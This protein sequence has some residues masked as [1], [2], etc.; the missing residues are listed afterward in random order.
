MTHD[1]T[2]KLIALLVVA[3]PNHEK[4]RDEKH[5]QMTV[6]LWEQMFAGD[7]FRLVQLATEK[8]IATSKW[9]PSIAELRDIIA[10]IT[11]PGV[12]P[13]DEAWR[14]VTKLLAIHE[15]LYQPT[16][17]YLPP[18][19]AEAV[20]TVGYD[21]LQAIHRAAA[22]GA[23]S[24]AGLD[25]VAFL[26]AYEAIRM[27]KREQGALPAAVRERLDRARAYYGDDSRDMLDRL[28]MRYQQNQGLLP[29]SQLTE[30]E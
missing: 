3:Y 22:N 24:K 19:I 25:R 28:D 14:E 4:F 21:E 11:M 20:D 27:R 12:L 6:A 18:E 8:H 30:E 5:I 1:E 23:S 9:P 13:P 2:V 26:Q 29:I 7:A 17:D 16:S 15:R 10:D